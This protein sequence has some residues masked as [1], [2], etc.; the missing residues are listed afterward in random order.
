LIRALPTGLRARAVLRL[1]RRTLRATYVGTRVVVR[2]RKRQGTVDVRASLFC[3][4]RESS[5]EPLCDFYAAAVSRFL[6]LYGLEAEVTLGACR[7]VGDPSCVI[8]VAL[9]NA[10]ESSTLN[11][12][13]RE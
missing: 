5:H 12:A 4:V 1:A 13:P 2:M 7:A 9:A 11:L 6:G 10:R 3:N 8:G